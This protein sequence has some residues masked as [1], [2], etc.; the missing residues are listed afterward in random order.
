MWTWNDE[1]KQFYLH[2]FT[3]EQPDLNLRSDAVK[4]EIKVRRPRQKK[5]GKNWST[6]NF[7][8]RILQQIIKFWIDKGVSG[9]RLDAAIHFV[10]DA[11]FRDEPLANP[12]K[13]KIERYDDLIHTRTA[14]QP[15]TYQVLH[16]IRTFTD[17]YTRHSNKR[18]W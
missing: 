16:E 9:T 12:N 4:T 17:D 15:E 2:Q 7:S 13:T 1:R 11:Q 5:T 18:D 10:E 3:P 6:N 14:N 8:F